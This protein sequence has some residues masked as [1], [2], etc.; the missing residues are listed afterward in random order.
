MRPIGIFDSGVGGLGICKLVAQ[1]LPHH[2]IVY[3][4]D[5]ANLPFGQKAP[6]QLNHISEKIVQFLIDQHDVQAVVIACNTATVTSIA[7]LRER[8]TIPII[9]AVPVVKPACQQTKTK[10]VALLVT[11]ATA[12]SAYLKDLINQHA[13][14]ADVL[15]VPC[16]GLV[17]HVEAGDFNSPALLALLETFLVPVRA[18]Q[19]DVVGL[20]CTHYPF[21]RDQIAA[22]LPPDVMLLDSNEPVAKQVERVMR[23]LPQP[24][25]MSQHTPTYVFYATKDAAHLCRV[26]RTLIGSMVERCNEVKLGD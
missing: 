22:L 10:R 6:E 11:A 23:G 16:P 8:F 5:N 18:H 12:G 26:A 1:C 3:F 4:A 24:E 9:G 7:H 19:A 13:D 21:L 20:G 25:A 2:D 17:E 14:G 15:V